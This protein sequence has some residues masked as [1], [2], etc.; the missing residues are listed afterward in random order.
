MAGKN[1]ITGRAFIKVNGELLR[2]KNGAKI[3]L[4]NPTREGQ[5]GDLGP[6][7]FVEK[8]TIPAVECTIFHKANTPVEQLENFTEGTV[9]FET[10]SGPSYVLVEA[11]QVNQ[12]ELT[13]QDSGGEIPL[14]F[15][16]LRTE[17]A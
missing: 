11:W 9:I 13:S 1:Q 12:I 6:E 17:R 7:G 8:P 4:G 15:E 14:R 2:S 5:A 3:W 10:D 16:G